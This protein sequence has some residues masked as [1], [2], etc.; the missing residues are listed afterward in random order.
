MS[1]YPGIDSEPFPC[2]I[3]SVALLAAPSV[4]AEPGAVRRDAVEHGGSSRWS[5][6]RGA[7]GSRSVVGT[8]TRVRL[9]GP[10]LELCT[11]T[12]IDV[13]SGSL[14]DI[15]GSPDDMKFQSSMTLFALAAADPASAFYKALDRWCG[16][17]LD[18]QTLRLLEAGGREC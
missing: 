5:G 7:L 2:R 16:G 9:L 3:C 15:F 6:A 12:V 11:G 14:H 10:R 4:R 13:E 8:C 1:R 17:T 18:A